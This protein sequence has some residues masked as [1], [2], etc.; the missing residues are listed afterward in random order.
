MCDPSAVVDHHRNHSVSRRGHNTRRIFHDDVIQ[1]ISSSTGDLQGLNMTSRKLSLPDFRHWD[2]GERGLEEEL[3]MERA[4]ESGGRDWMHDDYNRTLLPHDNDRML[5]LFRAFHLDE[6]I[7]DDGGDGEEETAATAD[8]AAL[9]W[10][11]NEQMDVLADTSK[12]LMRRDDDLTTP[13]GEDLAMG[14]DGGP[15]LDPLQDTSSLSSSS[16]LRNADLLGGGGVRGGRPELSNCQSLSLSHW[17]SEA[18]S[19]HS[20]PFCP[21]HHHIL[22]AASLAEPS[23]RSSVDRRNGRQVAD[24]S[25]AAASA[26]DHSSSEGASGAVVIAT[27]DDELTLS[28]HDQVLL[29]LM[30]NDL[31]GETGLDEK[32]EEDKKERQDGPSI[33]SSSSH[34]SIDRLQGHQLII[35]TH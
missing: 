15:R 26:R 9:P 3:E 21:Q 18:E 7:C 14:D 31:E 29:W 22:D 16:S 24:S 17:L 20:E 11:S 19:R 1:G 12:Y 33:S 10:R 23:I 2:V 5:H 4:M 28:R 27:A 25:A 13:R 30:S 8:E 34:S 35:S 32:E 6:S